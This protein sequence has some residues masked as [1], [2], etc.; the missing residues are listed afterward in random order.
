METHTPTPKPLMESLRDGQGPS[1]QIRRP[2]LSG[3]GVSCYGSAVVGV[4]LVSGA[5]SSDYLDSKWQR[6]LEQQG[7]AQEEPKTGQRP[8]ATRRADD[9]QPNYKLHKIVI[10]QDGGGG[11]RRLR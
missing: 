10:V 8:H 4:R 7:K 1:L 3:S 11:R 6:I 5:S 9:K 2:R